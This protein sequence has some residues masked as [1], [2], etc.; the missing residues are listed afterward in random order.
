MQKKKK[1][2]KVKILKKT[3]ISK[4]KSKAKITPGVKTP[5]KKTAI[6]G[7]DEKPEIKKIK[8]IREIINN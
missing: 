1:D 2:R 4:I 7:P 3:K 6:L 8:K 5:E